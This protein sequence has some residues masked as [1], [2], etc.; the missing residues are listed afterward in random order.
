MRRPPIARDMEPLFVVLIGAIVA[1]IFF[2]F[3][4]LRKT[5]LSFQEGMQNDRR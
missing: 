4:L 1:L 2:F 5:L 3:L